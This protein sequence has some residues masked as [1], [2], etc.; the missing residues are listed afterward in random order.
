M[1]YLPYRQR[2]SNKFQK[3]AGSGLDTLLQ[4]QMSHVQTSRQRNDNRGELDDANTTKEMESTDSNQG[5][6]RDVWN[7]LHSYRHS[8]LSSKIETTTSNLR[9]RRK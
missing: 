4:R 8:R 5:G 2:P 7:D 9:S 3:H 6:C 1:T